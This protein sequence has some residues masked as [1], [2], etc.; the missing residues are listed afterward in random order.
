MTFSLSLAYNTLMWW[1]VCMLAA[2]AVGLL[3]G[4][5]RWRIR[6][7]NWRKH[8]RQL[9][10]S[11]DNHHVAALPSPE[12]HFLRGCE[13]LQSG[14]VPHAVHDFRRAYH[15][16]P[17]YESAVLLAFTCMKMSDADMPRLLELLLETQAEMRRTDLPSCHREDRFLRLIA[18]PGE[19]PPPEASELAR[20][21]WMLPIARLREQITTA[22]RGQPPWARALLTDSAKITPHSLS[23]AA[24]ETAVS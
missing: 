8:V 14:H 19:P 23:T 16:C 21:L 10:G 7:L 9:A 11:T 24:T 22:L 17:S 13:T 4:L 6:V 18:P 3:A 2:G 5:L 1:L 15:G 12:A 20:T